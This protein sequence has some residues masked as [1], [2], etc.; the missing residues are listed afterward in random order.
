MAKD[1]KISKDSSK[2]KKSP[3]SAKDAQ[4]KSHGAHLKHDA[5]HKKAIPAKKGEHK[6]AEHVSKEAKDHKAQHKIVKKVEAKKGETKKT[7]AAHP[8]ASHK[9]HEKHDKKE[10][11]KKVE[12]KKTAKEQTAE[13]ISKTKQEEESKKLKA[14]NGKLKEKEKDKEKVEDEL[15]EETEDF[16]SDELSEYESELETAVSET[17]EDETAWPVPEAPAAAIP[18]VASKNNNQEV[19]LTDAEGRRYCRVRDCDQ[20]AMVDSYC[21]FHYLLLWKKIQIRKK[22]LADGKLERY[23]EELTARYPDK[24]LE[25]IRRDLRTE[26]DFL[27]AIQEL[28]IDESSTE[29]DFEDES[30]NF[31]EEVRSASTDTGLSD[32]EEY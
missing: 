13:L 21:R 11:T 20:I 8:V 10:L 3:T 22:I 19:I 18:T 31:I 29:N 26:K 17:E 15:L 5:K 32:E 9:P 24:F 27:S 6:K 30:S 7:P 12:V 2:M 23:V 25:V 16:G 28:E 4:K 1:K 14:T